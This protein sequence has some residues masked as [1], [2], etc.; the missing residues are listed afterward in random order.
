[1]EI[2]CFHVGGY[3]MGG[4]EGNGRKTIEG[5][6]ELDC[7]EVAMEGE[8]GLDGKRQPWK[9]KVDW[10]GKQQPWKEKVG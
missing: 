3:K 6:S 9:E 4:M 2:V 10:T 8:N 5:G 7:R 1:M